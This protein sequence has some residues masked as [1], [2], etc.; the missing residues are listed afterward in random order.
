MLRKQISSRVRIEKAIS[1]T[2]LEK[3]KSVGD[4]IVYYEHQ[5]IGQDDSE[6]ESSIR[7]I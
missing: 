6:R 5:N 2:P 1:T 3:V 4:G 7:N